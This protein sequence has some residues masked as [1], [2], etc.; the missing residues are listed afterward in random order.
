MFCSLLC[1]FFLTVTFPPETCPCSRR[2]NGNSVGPW[3]EVFTVFCSIILQT[4]FRPFPG[5][6]LAERA[7]KA[8]IA[9]NNISPSHITLVTMSGPVHREVCIVLR[10]ELLATTSTMF[11]F[12]LHPLDLI[13]TTLGCI[14]FS[15]CPHHFWNTESLLM[16]NYFIV[17]IWN[18]YI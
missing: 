16:C 12:L 7:G 4:C 17:P 18:L 8:L 13:L 3:P 5:L 9:P 1:T 15:P 14:A 11:Y 6:P 10:V 2:S